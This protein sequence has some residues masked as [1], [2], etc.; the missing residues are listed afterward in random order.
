MVSIVVDSK[1]WKPLP[2]QLLAKAVSAFSSLQ[3]SAPAHWQR[4]FAS[5]QVGDTI[6]IVEQC[7]GWYRGFVYPTASFLQGSLRTPVLGIF[8]SNFVV[9]LDLTLENVVQP[10]RSVAHLSGNFGRRKSYSYGS[11]SSPSSPVVG[12]IGGHFQAGVAPEKSSKSTLRTKTANGATFSS[13]ASFGS[14]SSVNSPTTATTSSLGGGSALGDHAIPAVPPIP[15]FILQQQQS[16]QSQQSQ[17]SSS[18]ATVAEPPANNVAFGGSKQK[19]DLLTPLFPTTHT[20]CGLLDPLVDEIS[21][22][23]RDWCDGMRQALLQQ[24][25]KVIQ[26]TKQLFDMLLQGRRQLIMEAL[27]EDEVVKVKRDLVAIIYHGNQLLGLPNTLRHPERGHILGSENAS[28][29]RLYKAQYLLSKAMQPEVK[30]LTLN[31]SFSSTEFGYIPLSLGVSNKDKHALS[32]EDG[33]LGHLY[34]DISL[35]NLRLYPQL[36]AGHGGPFAADADEF[37]EVVAGIYQYSKSPAKRGFIT[38]DFFALVGSDG[39]PRNVAKLLQSE[40]YNPATTLAQIGKLCRDDGYYTDRNVTLFTNLHQQEF[41]DPNGL[42]LVIRFVKLGRLGGPQDST[43]N[44]VYRRPFGVAVLELGP[45]FLNLGAL[46]DYGIHFIPCSNDANFTTLHECIIAERRELTTP[47]ANAGLGNGPISTNVASASSNGQPSQLNGLTSGNAA[48]LAVSSGGS[49][50]SMGPLG[51][52]ASLNAPQLNSAFGGY[53]GLNTLGLVSDNHSLQPGAQGS[54]FSNLSSSAAATAAIFS[55]SQ[56]IGGALPFPALTSNTGASAAGGVGAVVDGKGSQ[57]QDSIIVGTCLRFFTGD[58]SVLSRQFPLLSKDVGFT[59]RRGFSELGFLNSTE[60]KNTVYLTFCDADFGSLLKKTPSRFIEAR[61]AVRWLETIDGKDSWILNADAINRGGGHGTPKLS[62]IRLITFQNTLSPK[63]QET[64]QFDIPSTLHAKAHVIVTFYAHTHASSNLKQSSMASSGTNLTPTPFAF[65]VLPLKRG[66]SVLSDGMHE[67]STFK[68]DE[69]YINIPAM[70]LGL[71]LWANAQPEPP[72]EIKVAAVSAQSF[73]STHLLKEVVKV[74]TEL[75]STKFSKNPGLL[76]LLQFKSTASILIPSSANRKSAVD[77]LQTFRS[78]VDT[79]DMARFLPEILDTL[80][81]ILASPANEHGELNLS[82]LE[83]LCLVLDSVAGPKGSKYKNVVQNYIEEGLVKFPFV[84]RDLFKSLEAVIVDPVGKDYSSRVLKAWHYVV[85]IS[86]RS[87]QDYVSRTESKDAREELLDDIQSLS[88]SL[89]LEL[90]LMVGSLASTKLIGAQSTAIQNFSQFLSELIPIFSST[91]LAGLAV[92]FVDSVRASKFIIQVHRITMIY[93]LLKNPLFRE[94]RSRLL[95]VDA[96]IKWIRQCLTGEWDPISYAKAS[97]ANQQYH[98]EQQSLGHHADESQSYSGMAFSGSAPGSTSVS[99]QVKEREAQ[100]E[101]T[102][103]C[104]CLLA[105]VIDWGTDNIKA[106]GKSSDQGAVECSYITKGLVSLFPVLASTLY[107]VILTKYSA[108][109]NTE[110]LWASAATYGDVAEL[111]VAFASLLR[112]ILMYNSSNCLHGFFIKYAEVNGKPASAE[113]FFKVLLIFQ[114]MASDKCF[115]QN[116]TAIRLIVG[117]TIFR[118]LGEMAPVLDNLYS[119]VGGVAPANTGGLT[120]NALGS[121]DGAKLAKRVSVASSVGFYSK[122]WTEYFRTIAILLNGELSRLEALPEQGRRQ[123]SRMRMDFRHGLGSILV[124][125]W[126]K[127]LHIE[128]QLGKQLP[129]SS[130]KVLAD[131]YFKFKESIIPALLLLSLEMMLSPNGSLRELM[132]PFIFSLIEQEALMNHGNLSRIQ[133]S[134]IENV[135]DLLMV[136]KRGVQQSKWAFIR[137]T[138]FG[139]AS[140]AAVSKQQTDKFSGVQH[141]DTISELGDFAVQ[142][143]RRRQSTFG[144]NDS[145]QRTEKGLFDKVESIICQVVQYLEYCFVA[146]TLP[147]TQEWDDERISVILN[148]VEFIKRIDLRP[149]YLWYISEMAL[150]QVKHDN[151]VEAAHLLKLHA[152]MLDWSEALVPLPGGESITSY[153]LKR[154]LYS[155]IILLLEKGLYWESAAKLCQEWMLFEKSHCEFREIARLLDRESELYKKIVIENRFSPSYFRV[156]FYGLDWPAMLR[157]QQFVYRGEPLE[158]ISAFVDQML[159][160]YSGTQLVKSNGPVPAS[161]LASNQRWIQIVAVKPESLQLLVFAEE[162]RKERSQGRPPL[163]SLNS[164]SENTKRFSNYDAHEALWEPASVEKSLE[165]VRKASGALEV[166][167]DSVDLASGAL[168]SLPSYV[169][170]FYSA[171]QTRVFTFERP[172]KKSMVGQSGKEF[173]SRNVQQN[174]FLQL[175]IERSVLVTEDALPNWLRRSKV[176]AIERFELCPIENALAT[177]RNKNRELRQLASKYKPFVNNPSPGEFNLNP[178]TMSLNGAVD[179]PVNGGVNMYKETFLG[180]VFVSEFPDLAELV[181]HLEKEIMDQV[182][183]VDECLCIHQALVPKQ[184]EPLHQQLMLLFV[185]NFRSELE[186]IAKRDPKIFLHAKGFLDDM[187]RKPT[188]HQQPSNY[189]HDHERQVSMPSLGLNTGNPG[190]SS[191]SSDRP[192]A[193]NSGNGD[194]VMAA[195]AE[196]SLPSLPVECSSTSVSPNLN[197]V[198]PNSSFNGAVSLKWHRRGSQ[199]LGLLFA[200][201]SS[202]GNS[203]SSST[204][205]IQED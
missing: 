195:L 110:K 156:G 150:I 75:Y 106:L 21:A 32:T 63:W 142:G 149:M 112:F 144:L 159:S 198:T 91:E 15:S 205:V 43:G 100:R 59:D 164:Q 116:W 202:P 201:K 152:D 111:G 161:V 98:G 143:S 90:N 1:E 54:T 65:S 16:Q 2:T 118:C 186:S 52:S 71:P 70:Y 191:S 94:S 109:S 69:N 173:L 174:E 30:D 169:R 153:Q 84:W 180:P 68:Y 101:M 14:N 185:K 74:K 42:Y 58:K 83:T 139:L 108:S 123:V 28:L 34:C 56:G 53:S 23:L 188:H 107:D 95:L 85:R 105:E 49:V 89:L 167:E 10:R 120:P 51:V 78:T 146:R 127:I 200:P 117:H 57:V 192:T 140:W 39:K 104:I 29:T 160:R 73:A 48:G 124:E 133:A 31:N 79:V 55:G 183:I 80:F 130:A 125:R 129:L 197:A 40:L 22:T 148:L 5:L 119:G 17:N 38:E 24:Q 182:L 147:E 64:V 132:G 177:M 184:M 44:F 62:S 12:G 138:A 60:E 4:H 45:L 199:K 166:E 172:F 141:T 33:K 137:T 36:F 77:I 193:G 179:A 163:R 13:A 46:N 131:S 11:G 19:L 18:A 25:Y 178:F 99:S 151:W 6:Q 135:D 175:W 128:S 76:S 92:A 170:S 66:E 126:A 157:N 136:Q 93:S 102:R 194:S 113:L 82:I 121:D 81:T 97:L 189:E 204:P 154:M 155:D 196:K 67:L 134:L 41:N 203:S 61:C 168:N 86:L 50:A 35:P 145:F 103:I 181:L 187:S 96:I 27:S 87:F 7:A 20:V 122:L 72:A 47:V 8:P 88:K 37:I 26:A 176:V 165:L 9:V 158:R 162:Q 115:H 190:F 171:N 3:V 114:T